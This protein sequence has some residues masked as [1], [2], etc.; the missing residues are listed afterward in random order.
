MDDECCP[1]ELHFLRCLTYSSPPQ[2]TLLGTQPTH[3]LCVMDICC[4]FHTLFSPS[5]NVQCVVMQNRRD[6]LTRNAQTDTC[7]PKTQNTDDQIHGLRRPLHNTSSPPRTRRPTAS[8]IPD[9]AA[10]KLVTQTHCHHSPHAICN[11][12]QTPPQPMV[13]AIQGQGICVVKVLFD[14]THATLADAKSH[15]QAHT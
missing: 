9:T 4:S 10:H 14:A 11:H 15:R 5:C 2:N 12:N 3:S 6:T 13:P 7:T 8:R 1:A